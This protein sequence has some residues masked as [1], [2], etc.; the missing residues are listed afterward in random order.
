[1]FQLRKEDLSLYLYIKDVILK[2]FME[3]VDTDTL[4]YLPEI[5]FGD[6][7]VYQIDATDILPSPFEAGR[8]LVYFD[9]DFDDCL[10]TCTTCS[11]NPEQS[12][13][14]IVYDQNGVVI[15][16]SE[17]MIDY[18]DGRIITEST[19]QT[20]T[21]IDY[22]WNYIAVID[23]WLNVEAAFSPVVVVDIKGTDKKGYQLGGGKHVFRHVDLHIFASST[24]ERKDIME[25]LYEGLYLNS[26]ALLQF[27]QGSVLDFDGTFYGRRENPNKDET[28]FSRD[29]I[30]HVSNLMFENVTAR[31]IR[32]PSLADRAIESN[33]LSVL[34]A[35]RAKVSFDMVSYTAY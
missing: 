7:R 24:A 9:E 28:L 33:F 34:N 20:P 19:L 26:T 29:K 14:V 21:T 13:R 12:A 2:P 4:T 16:D 17:Y 10:V 27:P 11:G 8:G 30:P 5:S 23:E 15:P 18:I 31:N 6:S 22:H 1:M 3:F 35:H 25:C 32:L